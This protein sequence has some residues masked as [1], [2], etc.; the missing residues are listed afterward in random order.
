MEIG[1]ALKE[2]TGIAAEW[3]AGRTDETFEKVQRERLAGIYSVDAYYGS[4][5]SPIRQFKPAGILAPF[6]PLLLPEVSDP[7]V[8]FGGKLPFVDKD[9]SVFASALYPTQVILVNTDLVKPD[10]ISSY[11]DLLAPKWKGKIAMNDPTV[12]IGRGWVHGVIYTKILGPDFMR[13]LAK[14]EPVISRDLRLTAEWV[15]RGKYPILVPPQPTA[16]AEFLSIGAPIGY[17]MPREGTFLTSVMGTTVK[18]DR[19]PHPKAAQVF[20]NWFLSKEGQKLISKLGMIDS[21]RV[22]IDTGFLPPDV[23]RQTGV[24]YYAGSESEEAIQESYN[25]NIKLAGEIFGHLIR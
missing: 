4:P 10:E 17:V 11:Q 9:N 23:R 18:F 8:W 15:A 13:A 19:A 14:Q 16:A 1:K 2:K 25:N 21:A 12:G 20:I 5:G 6:P 3:V 24:K 22:D 7:R